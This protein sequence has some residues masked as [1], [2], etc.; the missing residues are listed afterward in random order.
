MTSYLAARNLTGLARGLEALRLVLK[1]PGSCSDEARE[2]V[3]G[4]CLWY[5]QGGQPYTC[6]QGAQL[7]CVHAHNVQ[8][9]C[10]EDFCRIF[11]IQVVHSY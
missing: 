10:R 6:M 2:K 1:L 9:V 4:W 11:Y 8:G 5:S 3:R 7:C